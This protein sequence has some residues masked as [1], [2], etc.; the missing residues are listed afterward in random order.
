MQL[1]ELVALLA[2]RFDDAPGDAMLALMMLC[3]GTRIGENRQS[4]WSDIMLSEC[5]WFLRAENTKTKIELRVP[6][7]D[8]ACALL[9]RYRDRQTV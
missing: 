2:E 3:H 7:A 6:L 1:P 4:C 9:R 8:Q 5:E